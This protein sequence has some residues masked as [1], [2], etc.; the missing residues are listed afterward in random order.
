VFVQAKISVQFRVNQHDVRT[1]FY[2]LTD[3]RQQI[4]AYIEDALRSAVPT[5]TLDD[6]F[7]R[8]DDIAKTVQETVSE[9]MSRFGFI[10]LK[11]LI[12]EL[13]PDEKVR[14]SM[15]EINAA[16]RQRMAAQELAN[17]D[18][19]KV[20]TK[21]QAEAEEARLRGQGIAD[22]RKAIVN[23]LSDS[24]KE[25]SDS[26]LSEKEV[27]SILMTNQYLDSLNRFADNKN[28]TIFLPATPEG[29]ENI[30]EQILSA[31]AVHDKR[32]GA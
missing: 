13:E 3:P 20:V 8:K 24:F 22:Q 32:G 30:R 29:I 25:L 6:A 5:L 10:I 18:K 2:E 15:N 21:A 28:S 19:I 4:Q 7:E 26:G 16:Q 14:E 12:T 31:L 11:T 17:A 27:M 23:G 1:A 9:E